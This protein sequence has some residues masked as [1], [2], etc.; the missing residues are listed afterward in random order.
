VEGTVPLFDG[1][2]VGNLSGYP[3]FH[4]RVGDRLIWS[5]H[6][7]LGSGLWAT[8]GTRGGTVRLAG[9]GT[10]I[11]TPFYDDPA[12]QATDS[13]LEV[14]VFGDALIFTA[15]RAGVG[16]E[17]FVSDGTP[18]GTRLLLDIVP[19]PASSGPGTVVAAANRAWF[20]S[21]LGGFTGLWSTDGTAAGTQRL[22][23]PGLF[24]ERLT[25]VGER[26]VFFQDN[27][28]QVELWSSDG[29][30]A[31]TGP[32]ETF[33][34]QGTS[35]S[36]LWIQVES[37]RG[38][39]IAAKGPEG[40]QI[41]ITDGTSAGTVRLT[42]FPNGISNRSQAPWTLSREALFYVAGNFTD[43]RKLMRVD[44]AT[45]LE[46][47]LFSTCDDDCGLVLSSRLHV[48][49]DL[50]YFTLL[51]QTIGLGP[52]YVASR[53]L[54]QTR[55][56]A[57]LVSSAGVGSDNR[58]YFLVK[59]VGA[60]LGHLWRTDESGSTV[61]RLSTSAAL[62]GPFELFP[63]SAGGQVF[64]A[65]DDNQHGTEL[66]AYEEST[67]NF[68]MVTDIER[69][70]A[71]SDPAG[72]VSLGSQLLFGVCR[73][74][75]DGP[76]VTD[77]SAA[78]TRLVSTE[79]SF[80][81]SVPT[82][83]PAQIVSLG[84][85]AL[86]EGTTGFA[87]QGLW[88]T[89]GSS[90]GTFQLLP[91]SNQVLET[92]VSAG[93]LGFLTVSG[94]ENEVWRSDGSVAGTY[95]VYPPSPGDPPLASTFLAEAGGRAW[96]EVQ[97]PSGGIDLWVSDGTVAGTRR[98]V[99]GQILSNGL[100]QELGLVSVNGDAY[101]FTSTPYSEYRLWRSGGSPETTEVVFETTKDPFFHPTNFVAFAGEIY[102][103][104][105]NDFGQNL[106]R[107]DGSTK[108]ARI[109]A[110]FP[111]FE[112]RPS[113][114]PSV[115]LTVAGDR[116]FLV[117]A[118]PVHGAELWVTDGG[119]EGTRL[120]S[121]I[122]PGPHSSRI[123]HL[124]ADGDRVWYTASDG[125]HGVEL[126]TSDGSPEG[127]YLVHDLSPGNGS[128]RP[129]SLTITEDHLFFAA[130]DAWS[131]RELWAVELNSDGGCVPSERYLCLQ[132]GRFRVEAAWVDF[133]ANAGEGK[134]VALTADTG[135][136]WFF[137]NT[138]VETVIKVL[139]GNPVNGHF[140]TFFGALSNVEYAMTVTDT[141][142]GLTRRYYNPS[143]RFASVGDTES[144]GPKGAKD[145][146]TEAT[147]TAGEPILVDR[148]FDPSSLKAA[149]SDG[150]LQ[151]CLNG[152][153]FTVTAERE[154]FQGNTGVGTA[155]PLT[156]DTGYF[157]FFRDTN[158][159]VVLKVLDGRP[160]NG[161]YWVFYG[162]LSNV[163]YR[164]TVTDTQTGEVKVYENPTRRFASV[165][166]TEAF[167]D[168]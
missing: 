84:S 59:S 40:S 121:D 72:L 105:E 116:L 45:L 36:P 100:D 164:L 3:E 163:G 39:F 153:R 130:D 78:G 2:V 126:W 48:A 96:F 56:L 139:D 131:G 20:T 97:Q 21:G 82:G 128:S 168:G 149:C 71:D 74:C 80:N 10:D 162:A 86:F 118:D 127:T 161:N 141:Q 107:T 167:G 33:E 154:D 17:V 91:F 38:I 68:G 159:E 157:W 102:F 136:F 94:F 160:L 31:G 62:R 166:D 69:S 110:E 57:D 103:V 95:K 64:L 76:W 98:A 145:A 117:V 19:G 24:P 1:Q 152:D 52:L 142:T 65:A 43:G 50:V 148:Y 106:W 73:T 115:Q 158:V 18:A 124:T 123:D 5:S 75:L 13:F 9:H 81:A 12:L 7:R 54:S 119:S 101:F 132:E 29:T 143:R 104:T 51:D 112:P 135:Y 58:L 87:N 61:E 4:G 30:L 35:G 41:W 63:S 44:L 122:L 28:T 125:E 55:K 77:G 129:E 34:G 134:A 108:G 46:V 93:G 8:D 6:S 155:V 49:R 85:V 114:R 22:F 88:R 67:Q 92:L 32:I 23:G 120:V 150:P 146:V 37:G 90:Q 26:A 15:G 144:F 89:D 66:W 140:W 113:L 47:E 27:H 99:D 156:A 42:D 53:T 79:V 70:V 165:G 147:S 151:L 138:N 16:S 133:Q 25:A 83:R 11:E 109:V 137:K 111:R 60:F 14:G